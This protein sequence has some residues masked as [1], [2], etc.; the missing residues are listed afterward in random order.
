MNQMIAYCGIDCHTCP[1]YLATLET[2]DAKRNAMRVSIAQLYTQEYGV[3]VTAQDVPDCDGCRSETGRLFAGCAQCQIRSCAIS[4][5]V[6][7]CAFCEEYTC[8]KLQ[9]HFKSYPNAEI[10]LR[11]LKAQTL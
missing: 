3:N 9:K 5:N 4:R 10:R 7:S 6:L 11:S 8:E 2:D 1:I